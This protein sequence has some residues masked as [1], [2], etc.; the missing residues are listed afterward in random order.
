M[1]SFHARLARRKPPISDQS[2]DCRV[3][4]PEVKK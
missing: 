2:Q 1:T 4:L 3:F